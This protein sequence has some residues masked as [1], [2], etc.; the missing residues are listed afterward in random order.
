MLRNRYQPRND[1]TV[2]TVSF[3]RNFGRSSVE[4][5]STMAE[6]VCPSRRGKRNS[7]GWIFQRAKPPKK[8]EAPRKARTVAPLAFLD[9]GARLTSAGRAA[10]VASCPFVARG[11][12]SGNSRGVKR[13]SKR[14][15]RVPSPRRFRF[16]PL[17]FPRPGGESQF[18]P[19]QT[20]KNVASASK[21]FFQ[22]L[23]SSAP[24]SGDQEKRRFW[25]ILRLPLSRCASLAR[26]SREKEEKGERGFS[27]SLSSGSP[28]LGLDDLLSVIEWKTT[29]FRS[30]TQFSEDVALSFDL[31]ARIAISNR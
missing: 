9:A 3:G 12:H 19:R 25:P 21:S 11:E 29:M 5:R 22:A 6:K 30:R 2:H 16:V 15:S 27:S 1:Q 20:E 31:S 14:R 23:C 7:L 4:K 24:R 18:I 8:T 17:Y 10:R 13:A 26:A 28:R